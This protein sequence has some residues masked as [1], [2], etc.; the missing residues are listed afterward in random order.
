MM[1]MMIIMIK[2]RTVMVT[3][4]VASSASPM[5]ST[6][7]LKCIKESA[8]PFAKAKLVSAKGRGVF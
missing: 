7:L 2:V 4:I 3:V 8:D 6:S 1:T 5:V